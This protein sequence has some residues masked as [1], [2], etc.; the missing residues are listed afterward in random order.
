M[1]FYAHDVET[2][3]I[4]IFYNKFNLEL[5]SFAD[6]LLGSIELYTQ[7]SNRLREEVILAFPEY[8]NMTDTVYFGEVDHVIPWQIDHLICWRS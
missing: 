5:R 1:H 2:R 3:D 6:H 8:Q 7:K 4:D